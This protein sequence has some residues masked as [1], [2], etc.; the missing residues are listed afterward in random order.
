M[1][2]V[3]ST[4]KLALA[5]CIKPLIKSSRLKGNHIFQLNKVHEKKKKEY[6]FQKERG[7]FKTPCALR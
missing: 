5:S 2:T 6:G 7:M 3:M 4:T 1:L